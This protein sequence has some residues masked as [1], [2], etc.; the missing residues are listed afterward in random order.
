VREQEEVPSSPPNGF[1]GFAAPIAVPDRTAAYFRDSAVRSAAVRREPA[2]MRDRS[3]DGNGSAA[4]RA[5]T[6]RTGPRPD[7]EIRGRAQ[8]S[9]G[10]QAIHLGAVIVVS[11]AR[12]QRST[13]TPCPPQHLLAVMAVMAGGP[14]LFDLLASALPSVTRKPLKSRVG[15]GVRR[16]A[17]GE[18][19]PVL[20]VPRDVGRHRAGVA[21]ADELLQA[22]QL[23]ADRRQE[24]RWGRAIPGK[25][26]EI[27]T[28]THMNSFL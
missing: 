8:K 2:S 15:E 26:R 11:S 24:L 18:E 6:A 1:E 22:G 9:V 23:G 4:I 5:R 20:A 16:V 27:A 3:S 17:A 21:Q 12:A 25:I 19:L 28:L 13:S 14:R 10:V 7:R